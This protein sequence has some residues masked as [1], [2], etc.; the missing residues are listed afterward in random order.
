MLPC[1]QS[2]MAISKKILLIMCC[3]Q[4]VFYVQKCVASTNQSRDTGSHS[5]LMKSRQ[6]DSFSTTKDFPW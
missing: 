4:V 5:V 2:P 1:I 3:W 6:L